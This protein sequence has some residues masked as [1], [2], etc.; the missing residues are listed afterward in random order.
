[1]MHYLSNEKIIGPPGTVK[2]AQTV[3]LR[4]KLTRWP[5]LNASANTSKNIR[6]DG[7]GQAFAGSCPRRIY[8]RALG[9]NQ[10]ILVGLRTRFRL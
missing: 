2:K 10:V 6:R 8:V 1:M 7:R 5:E 4:G 3:D 9:Q